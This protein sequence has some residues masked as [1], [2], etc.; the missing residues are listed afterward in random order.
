MILNKI[1]LTVDLKHKEA[2]RKRVYKT[3]GT[4]IIYSPNSPFPHAT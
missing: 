2:N 4:N 1:I 3:L